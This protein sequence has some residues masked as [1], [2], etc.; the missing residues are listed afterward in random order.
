M[1]NSDGQGGVQCDSYQGRVNGIR[2][3]C[4]LMER[5]DG[6]LKGVK[7]VE[8]CVKEAYHSID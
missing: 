6:H 7:G 2:K 4:Y 5:Y 1:K 8:R 3:L